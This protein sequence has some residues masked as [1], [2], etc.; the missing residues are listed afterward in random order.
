ML[1]LCRIFLTLAAFVAA[2]MPTVASAHPLLLALLGSGLMH[3]HAGVALG[4]GLAFGRFVHVPPAPRY[5]G[6]VNGYGYYR[7]YG[8]PTYG[9]GRFSQYGSY[10]WYRGYRQLGQSAEYGASL[11]P[12]A[13]GY[14]EYPS[15][16][17]SDKTSS[18]TY[19]THDSCDYGYG[20]ECPNWVPYE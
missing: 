6:F 18:N 9:A 13:Y 10:G 19:S 8:V 15:G 7:S 11:A 16:S 3:A 4:H 17:S 12:Y 1:I 20:Y 14:E 5:G 2:N